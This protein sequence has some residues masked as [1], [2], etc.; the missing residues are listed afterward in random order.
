M[1]ND[2][3]LIL[4]LNLIVNSCIKFYKDLPQEKNDVNENKNKIIIED[5]DDGFNL[6]NDNVPKPENKIEEKKDNTNK[7]YNLFNNKFFKLDLTSDK[8]VNILNHLFNYLNS[9]KIFRLATYEIILTD[10]QL[11]IKTYIEHN[12]NNPEIKRA[13]ILKLLSSVDEQFTKM[14]NLI[15]KD[16]NMI[17]FLFDSCTK[18]YEHYVKNAEKKISDLITLPNILV[19]IIYLDKIEEIPDYLREDKDNEEFLRN[20]IFNIFFINDIINELKDNKNDIIK[21]KKFPLEIE[22]IKFS[23]GKEYSEKDL[24]EDYVHCKIFRNN[25]YVF[26]QAI[27]TADMLYLGEVL[28]GSFKDLSRIKIFK[29]IPLRYL[30]IKNGENDILLNLSDKTNKITRKNIIKMDCLN[31]NNRITM[32]NYLHQQIMFC[33]SL[34]QSLFTSYM[35]DMKKKLHEI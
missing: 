26:S 17:K 31:Y 32:Y 4:L 1:C 23:I 6:I 18:A 5:D 14:F 28:S 27:I 15:N 24:G 7:V 21:S 9:T 33:L 11:L 20:Y 35:E 34:E 22:T 2:D 8:S 12:N 19:P 25:N 16:N 13:L 30:E 3:A 10:I 29:K